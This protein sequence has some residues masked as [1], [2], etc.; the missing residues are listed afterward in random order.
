MICQEK[1]SILHMLFLITFSLCLLRYYHCP[2][3]IKKSCHSGTLTKWLRSCSHRIFVSRKVPHMYTCTCNVIETWGLQAT[4]LEVE[5][6]PKIWTHI[7]DWWRLIHW[8]HTV[9]VWAN[10]SPCQRQ[11]FKVWPIQASSPSLHQP[12]SKNNESLLVG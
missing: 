5:V 3:K 4:F 2:E 6:P 10:T 7:T 9:H 8:W 11:H 12:C 1:Q